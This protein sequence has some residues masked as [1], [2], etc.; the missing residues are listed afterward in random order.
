MQLKKKEF[1]CVGCRLVCDMKPD[2]HRW[3]QWLCNLCPADGSDEVSGW[4]DKPWYIVPVDRTSHPEN[5]VY[6]SSSAVDFG[7]YPEERAKL[8]LK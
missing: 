5:W 3:A 8:G 6:R 1:I 4:D 2:S 7:A